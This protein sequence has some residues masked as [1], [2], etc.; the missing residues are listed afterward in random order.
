MDGFSAESGVVVMAAT[1]RPDILDNA[2]LRPGR[3][4]RQVVVDLPDITGRAEILALHAQKAP[5]A[6]EVELERIAAQTPGF[7]GAD[8]ANLI[9]EASLLAVRAGEPTIGQRELEEAVDRVL[10]GPERKSHILSEQERR[11]IAVHEA[12]HAIVAWAID[13]PVALQK[14]SIVARG[15]GRGGSTLYAAADKLVLSHL[16]LTKGLVTMM[17]GAA[18]E[19][20]VFSML[21]TGVEDDLHDATRVAHA[22]VVSYG[23]STELGPVA[24]GEKQGEVFI[25][26]D[27]ANLSNVAPATLELVDAEVR[28]TVREA[29]ETGRHVLRRNRALLDELAGQLLERET[30]SGPSL[31]VY[32]EAVEHWNTPLIPALHG[33]AEADT[34]Q[35]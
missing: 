20:L 4:D 29:E 7:T 32:R 34:D 35:L 16:D 1:N 26:R 24:I 21:S 15:R 28:R 2:L 5:L 25:G 8:L 19:D 11:R 12:G 17:A 22:M 3:F 27:L 33:R 31:D 23:M 9:N 13:N 30:L 6:A 18:A 14:L 10:S